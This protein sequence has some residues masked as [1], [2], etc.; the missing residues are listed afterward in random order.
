MAN[1]TGVCS[2][3]INVK[4]FSLNCSFVY[5]LPK[6]IQ[7]HIFLCNKCRAIEYEKSKDCSSTCFIGL[8]QKCNDSKGPNE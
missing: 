1:A 4:Y 7:G 5:V 3:G 8:H 6:P 2:T